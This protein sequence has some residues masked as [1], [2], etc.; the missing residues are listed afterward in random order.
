VFVTDEIGND[1]NIWQGRA[2]CMAFVGGFLTFMS[3]GS[4]PSFVED[5][6][7]THASLLLLFIFLPKLN[8]KN[9]ACR[10]LMEDDVHHHHIYRCEFLR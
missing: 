3:I 8:F 10:S 2:G 9:A 5:M 7:V 6:K 4:F 1:G